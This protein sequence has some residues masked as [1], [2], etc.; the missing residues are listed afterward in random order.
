MARPQKATEERLEEIR[1]AAANAAPAAGTP[2]LIRNKESYY[3]L[4]VLKA[5][6]WTWEVPLYF[7]VG[8]IA[9]M[10]SCVALAAQLLGADMGLVRSALWVAILGAAICPI[11]LIT[12]LGRPGRFLAMLRVAK[13]QSPM[14]VGVWTL[15]AF[16]GCVLLAVVANE[17]IVRGYIGPVTIGARW[18]GE[19]MGTV[20]GLVLVSYT[21]VLIGATAN[22]VWSHN[23]RALP[24]HFVAAGLGGA[25]AVLELMGYLIPATQ[26]IGVA[27][28]AIETLLGVHF[29]LSRLPVNAP[30]HRGKSALAFRIAGT[31][32]GPGALLL[33]LLFDS[34][35]GRRA[36]A[37]C[38]LAG[39]LLSRYAWIW[40]G[41]ASA[42][43]PEVVFQLQR[44]A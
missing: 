13:I 40:A 4:P 17:M 21:G 39:T 38:F 14:S 31:M 2:V 18:A 23:R 1:R 19:V 35:P 9:G 24:P 25:G 37:I 22:P 33:R 28:A 11:F 41:V 36:A 43:D 5:P 3:N 8:G 15:L 30:L 32:A 27:A 7:F 29:E 44:R 26:F 10:S 16:S 20:T 6:V 12:D 42:K 34:I